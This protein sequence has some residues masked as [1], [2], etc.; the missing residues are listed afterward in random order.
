MKF[1]IGVDLEGVACV[2]GAPGGTL[3]DSRNLEFAKLQGSREADAAAR[4]LLSASPAST[5]L[6]VESASSAIT[7]WTTR[8]K[9]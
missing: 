1:V 7:R 2:V 4:G 5:N 6:S 9:R 3:N 8:P